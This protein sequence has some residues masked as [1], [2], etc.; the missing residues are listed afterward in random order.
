MIPSTPI[1]HVLGPTAGLR[2]IETGRVAPMEVALGRIHA[3]DKE[4]VFERIRRVR[5]TGGPFSAEFRVMNESGKVRWVLNR[6]TLIADDR[7]MHGQGA[8]IDT[9]DPHSD[10]FISAASLNQHY[11]DPLIAA[12]DHCLKMHTTLKQ[13]IIPLSGA[14]QK[15]SWLGLGDH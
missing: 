10:V 14:F 15:C 6:G 1:S 5:Q 11:D 12:A 9:T 8:Y 13:A 4:W 3:D 7:K 2:S